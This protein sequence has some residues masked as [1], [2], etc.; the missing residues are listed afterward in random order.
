MDRVTIIGLGLVGGSLALALKKS[1]GSGTHIIGCSRRSETVAKARERDIIDVGADNPVDAVREADLVIIATPVLAIKNMLRDIAA[2]LKSDCVVTDAGSTKI[3]VMEWAAEYL[4]GNIN[5]IG[6]HPMAGKEKSGIDEADADLFRNCVYCITPSPD[7]T[8]EAI[9]SLQGMVEVIGA[10]P[11]VI[12]AEKHDKLVAGV[13]HLPMILSA[14]FVSATADNP[15]WPEMAKIAA[16]G[17]RDLSRLASGNPEMN[18]DICATNKEQIL[19]WLDRYIIE[20]NKYRSLID[21][22]G[23]DIKDE[24]QRAREA[25]EKWLKGDKR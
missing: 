3:K 13:S 17:Y 8:R 16:G 25:R 14:A 24:L 20:L 19:H 22:S 12:D 11:L 2:G 10:R 5:F 1:W 9:M 6:G 15:L 18:S 21:E 7:A 4:P 23:E